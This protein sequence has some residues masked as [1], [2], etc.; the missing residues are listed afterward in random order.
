MVALAIFFWGGGQHNSHLL[1]VT[2]DVVTCKYSNSCVR[3]LTY[4]HLAIR[5]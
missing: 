4:T 3:A 2:R 5:I 1:E